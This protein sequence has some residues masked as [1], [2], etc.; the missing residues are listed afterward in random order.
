MNRMSGG[1]VILRP[2]CRYC[3]RERRD[4]LRAVRENPFCQACLHQRVALAIARAPATSTRDGRYMIVT[5][6]VGGKRA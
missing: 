2:R 3:G 4:S 5:R 1:A 6:G